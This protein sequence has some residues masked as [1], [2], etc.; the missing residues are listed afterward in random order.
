L[1][2]PYSEN[3]PQGDAFHNHGG[4]QME[5]PNCRRFQKNLPAGA[6]NNGRITDKIKKSDDIYNKILSNL[7]FINKFWYEVYICT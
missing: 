1:A 7:T 4:H 6:S 2:V 3:G 5:C